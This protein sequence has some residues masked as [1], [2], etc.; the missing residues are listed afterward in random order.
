MERS[1]ALCGFKRKTDISCLSEVR[2]LIPLYTPPCRSTGFILEGFPHTPDEVQ[3]MLQRQLFPDL[4]VIMAVE[5]SDVQERLLPTYL[6]KWQEKRDLF[7]TQ[8]T[9]LRDLRKKNWVST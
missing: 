1:S 5:V 9:L 8:L 7:K 6:K 2:R 3:Y 4:V